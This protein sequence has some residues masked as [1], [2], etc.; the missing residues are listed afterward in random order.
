M[1]LR[2]TM[3]VLCA[4][5]TLACVPGCDPPKTKSLTS[6]RQVTY[7]ELQSELTVWKSE[8]EAK[9]KADAEEDARQIRAAEAQAKRDA[10]DARRKAN[11]KL[12]QMDLDASTIREELDATLAQ[13]TDGFSFRVD[14]IRSSAQNRIATDISSNEKMQAKA[15]SAV[16]EL[17]RKSEQLSSLTKLGLGGAKIAASFV[18]GATPAIDAVTAL[19]GTTGVLGVGGMVYSRIQLGK[20][21]QENESLAQEKSKV[22]K[23][24]ADAVDAHA[25][26]LAAMEKVISSFDHLKDVKPD[27]VNIM[28]TVDAAGRLILDEW[29]GPDGK[30]LVNKLQ[31]HA[32]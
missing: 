15:D 32:A 10:E 11:R 6:D 25:A 24:H 5:V 30:A 7:D 27:L 16:A 19:L 3:A 28:K 9:A 23:D 22:E 14:D 12:A 29:Q 17:N 18:P 1:R 26:D 20:K 21:K 4:L 31:Q 2:N 8:Q 13:I